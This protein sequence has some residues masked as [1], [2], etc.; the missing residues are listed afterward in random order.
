L[1][2]KSSKY[3][4]GSLGILHYRFGLLI[5]VKGNPTITRPPLLRE[6][7]FQ[8]LLAAAQILQECSDR[9]VAESKVG[10]AGFSDGTIADAE[11]AQPVQVVPLT[12]QDAEVP[13]CCVAADVMPIPRTDVES[14]M[15]KNNPLIP[16]DTAY[17]LSVL[18]SSWK[19]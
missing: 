10:C 19:P 1:G 11:N 13:A 6:N 4:D 16:P 17:Q 2:E 9:R 14:F 7:T 12:L 15:P 5:D 8:Q 18:T 3:S